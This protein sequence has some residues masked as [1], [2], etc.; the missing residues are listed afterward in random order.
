MGAAE[1]AAVLKGTRLLHHDVRRLQCRA[2]PGPGMG[3]A[4]RDPRDP[5]VD[6][7]DWVE[8]IG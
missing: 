7:V 1:V 4:T 8:R 3:G 2:R 6:A 5:N